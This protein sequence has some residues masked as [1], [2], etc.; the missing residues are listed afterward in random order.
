[1]LLSNENKV[2]NHLLSSSAG[3]D[4]CRIFRYVL[5]NEKFLIN[6]DVFNEKNIYSFNQYTRSASVD[7]A[8]HNSDVE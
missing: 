1:M 6:V 5:K 4:D 7:S 2:A 8:W 3:S